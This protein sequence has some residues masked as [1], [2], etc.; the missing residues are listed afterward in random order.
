MPNKVDS[1]LLLADAPVP[2]ETI[3]GWSVGQLRAAGDWAL[4]T[5]LRAA[6][7]AHVRVPVKPAHVIAGQVK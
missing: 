3:L 5:Y 7:N 6:D 4:R 1:L 2:M